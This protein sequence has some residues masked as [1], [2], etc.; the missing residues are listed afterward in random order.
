[1]PYQDWESSTKKR[2]TSY[3]KRTSTP[4]TKS[5]KSYASSS[6]GNNRMASYAA[7]SPKPK[8]TKKPDFVSAVKSTY[9]Q[10]TGDNSPTSRFVNQVRFG[11]SDSAKTEY[12]RLSKTV[13][14]W[15]NMDEADR[16]QM[17]RKPQIM[18]QLPHA[19]IDNPRTPAQV[20]WAKANPN[21]GKDGKSKQ[22]SVK[23]PVASVAGGVT[24][25]NSVDPTLPSWQKK[26]NPGQRRYGYGR[27]GTQLTGAGGISDD[28]LAIG[29][30]MLGGR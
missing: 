18:E 9:N 17:A 3:F 22:Q 1:M 7:M 8:S 24:D 12:D 14:S 5:T 20:A 2:P 30:S 16:V 28:A 11:M 13:Y 15:D 25:I 10:W 23:Q 6:A 29:V 21:H 27:R 19:F 26:R 4:K